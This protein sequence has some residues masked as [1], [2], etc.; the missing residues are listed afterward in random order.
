ME[1]DIPSILNVRQNILQARKDN[2]SKWI[3]YKGVNSSRQHNQNIYVP[4]DRVSNDMKQELIE[5]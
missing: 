1:G 3:V 5:L 2:K 4:N